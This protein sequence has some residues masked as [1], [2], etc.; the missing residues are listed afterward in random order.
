[1][2]AKESAQYI[3]YVYTHAPVPGGGF[4]T[5]F[6][7]HSKVKNNLYARTDNG[8]VYRNDFSEKSWLSLMDHVKAT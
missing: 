6:C 1:M 8:G 2:Q 4:V 5:G 3:P 7:F